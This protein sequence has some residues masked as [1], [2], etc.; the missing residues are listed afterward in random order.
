MVVFKIDI[1]RVLARPAERD[2]VVSGDAHG[3]PPRVAV[4]TVEPETCHIHV[5]RLRRHLQR[6]K[7]TH[8]LP[9]VFGADPVCLAGEVDLFKPSIPEAGDHSSTVN[10]K[11]YS[12]NYIV[13]ILRAIFTIKSS[14]LRFNAPEVA[15]AQRIGIQPVGEGL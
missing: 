4:Q 8:A 6:L 13:Y 11:P 2:A 3:P 9:D 5:F 12:V 1:M 14:G 7:D 10:R 15:P